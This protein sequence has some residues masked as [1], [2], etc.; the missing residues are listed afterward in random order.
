MCGLCYTPTHVPV[1]PLW[2]SLKNPN[3]VL[4]YHLEMKELST[5]DEVT[6]LGHRIRQSDKLPLQPSLEL[7]LVC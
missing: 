2:K 6:T 4:P 5:Q 3:L 7:H 1:S